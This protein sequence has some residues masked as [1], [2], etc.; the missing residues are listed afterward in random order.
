MQANRVANQIRTGTSRSCQSSSV[1]TSVW[2]KLADM[3]KDDATG[4]CDNRWSQR[5]ERV[6][7]DAKTLVC[8][9]SLQWISPLFDWSTIDLS[10]CGVL[11]MNQCSEAV[12]SKLWWFGCVWERVDRDT[13]HYAGAWQCMYGWNL[14]RNAMFYQS[15]FSGLETNICG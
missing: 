15:Q 8:V 14:L 9:W 2:R 5:V 4:T 11:C 12:V 6:D 1:I 3:A 10:I 13:D 7:R